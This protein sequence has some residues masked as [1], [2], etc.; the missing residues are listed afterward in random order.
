MSLYIDIY[1]RYIDIHPTS[2]DIYR[3]QPLVPK[4]S[5][6]VELIDSRSKVVEAFSTTGGV[7]FTNGPMLVQSQSPLKRHF[8]ITGTPIPRFKAAGNF[9]L[10]SWFP[11]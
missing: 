6:A 8:Y 7:Q 2:I 9:L 11:F 5:A 4:P 1:R 3:P 10:F